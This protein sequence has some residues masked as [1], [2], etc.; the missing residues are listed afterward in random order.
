GAAGHVSGL[1]IPGLWCLPALTSTV[2]TPDEP[3]RPVPT[4]G[5]GGCS[6]FL[7]GGA[8]QHLVHRDPAG[9]AHDVVDGVGD[10]FGL[11]ALHV[12]EPPLHGLLDL[13]PV[14]AG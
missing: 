14:V 6:A 10:V 4:P 12:A 5:P 11:Q 1:T 2:V 7:F 9:A 3:V 13:R 8:D